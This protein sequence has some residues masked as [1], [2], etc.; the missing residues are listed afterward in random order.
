[1][2]EKIIYSKWLAYTL[3]KQGYKL[4]RTDINPNYPQFLC[5]IFAD[6]EELEKAITAATAAHK[7]N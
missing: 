6:N 3:R 4:L 7:A 1:M 5:Y 2:K